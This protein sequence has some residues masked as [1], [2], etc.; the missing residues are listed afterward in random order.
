MLQHL[1]C[2]R[3]GISFEFQPRHRSRPTRRFCS[4]RCAGLATW[5]HRGR[6]TPQ[7]RFWAKVQKTD[8]CWFW[9]AVRNEDGY[10]QFKFKGR[11]V[12]A[13]GLA[14]TWLVGPIEEGLEFDHLC[15]VRWCV[16]PAHLEP[17][18]HAVNSS[19]GFGSSAINARKDCCVHGHP[20]NE[21]NTYIGKNKKGRPT[22]T[23][24]ACRR[25]IDHRRVPRRRQK[26]LS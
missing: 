12:G 4:I 15:R 22:R 13:H 10:G 17:V 26:L 19:R 20:F 1:V 2:E 7:E 9:T 11:M 18:P 25:A 24:R 3:C 8:T 23:C 21:A 14:Y 5:D 16:N 6:R